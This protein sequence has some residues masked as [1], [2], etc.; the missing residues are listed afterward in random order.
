MSEDKSVNYQCEG[1]FN[2][3]KSSY[4]DKKKTYEF[5]CNVWSCTACH[6]DQK[7]LTPEEIQAIRQKRSNQSYYPKPK[8]CDGNCGYC[9]SKIYGRRNYH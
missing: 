1:I 8:R 3:S 9:I 5:Y 2:Q 6:Q 4:S 7:K